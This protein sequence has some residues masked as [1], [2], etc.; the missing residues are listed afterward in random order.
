MKALNNLGTV[1]T[2]VF[3]ACLAALV[4]E[5]LYVLWRRRRFLRRSVT[6]SGS[7]G[8]FRS[9]SDS[10][11]TEPSKELLYFF[12]WKNQTPRIEPDSTTPQAASAVAPPVPADD[13]DA[14]VEEM[15][16]L[17]GMYGPSRVLFTIKEEE[18]EVT[19]NDDSSIENE[20]VKSKKRKKSSDF[21]FEGA[22]ANDV[23]VE[24]E[25]DD[26][27]TP[28]WTPCASPQY[29]YTPSPS[30][31]R[32]GN[33]SRKNSGTENEVSVVVLGDSGENTTM[34]FVSIEVHSK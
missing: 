5:I 21:C 30:P 7:D 15:L 4:V 19:E 1:L 18:M 8:E 11:Y 6:S 3:S 24:V 34:S 28:F 12:C 10:L 32:D 13:A 25:V 33:L 31:P 29:Y 23:V 27:T 20:L 26:V 16:K 2:V 22:V 17:Q 14:L 9:N